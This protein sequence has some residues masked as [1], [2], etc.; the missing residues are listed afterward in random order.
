MIT[1]IKIYFCVRL[2]LYALEGITRMAL[3]NVKVMHEAKE[4]K[5]GGK[6]YK[7]TISWD[8]LKLLKQIKDN[9]VQMWKL[10]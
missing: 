6:K 3:N 5:K 9:I 8:G 1:V 2:T 7:I 4:A 10:L